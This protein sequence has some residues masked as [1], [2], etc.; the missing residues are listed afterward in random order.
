MADSD[1]QSPAKKRIVNTVYLLTVLTIVLLIGFVFFF[2][3]LAVFWQSESAVAE[4]EPVADETLLERFGGWVF[5]DEREPEPEAIAVETAVFPTPT[6]QP[7]VP[8]TTPEPEPFGTL[9]IPE[10][11]VAQPI[12]PIFI[13]DGQW[14]I[15][16]IGGEIG[17]LES[18]GRHPHDEL[19]M[20]FTGHVT[21]PW[22]DIEGPFANLIFLEH[23]EE[24]IY[25]WNGTDYIYEVERIFRVDPAAVD[26]LYQSEGNKLMLVTCSGW[27]FVGREYDERLVTRAVLVREEPS[28]QDAG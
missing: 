22:P 11:E 17:H 8:T 28:P 21:L 2:A 12:I 20:T 10:I 18:T 9:I 16:E 5:S 25:R 1:L 4:V 13:R 3:S 24:I 7:T 19:A 14:D 6:P 23:G 27:D 26:L 15:S